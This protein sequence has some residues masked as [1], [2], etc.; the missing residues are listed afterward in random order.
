MKKLKLELDQLEV[1]SFTAQDEEKASGTVNGMATYYP[2]GCRPSYY[3]TECLCTGAEG[4]Y[5]SLYCSQG[6]VGPGEPYGT[7][8]AGCMTNANGEC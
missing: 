3:K 7:C 2:D 4:C 6:G 5:P 8:Y 1:S